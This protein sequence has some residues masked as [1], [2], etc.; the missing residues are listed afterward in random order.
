MPLK[1]PLG[2]TTQATVGAVEEA[3]KKLD[4]IGIDRPIKDELELEEFM[5]KDQDV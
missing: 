3:S 4:E 1:D 2:Q 5:P